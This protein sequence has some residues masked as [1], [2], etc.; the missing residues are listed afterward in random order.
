V[1]GKF[2]ISW[3]DTTRGGTEQVDADDFVEEGVWTT[4][5]R[6]KLGTTQQMEQVLRVRSENIQR[7]E[8]DE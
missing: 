3:N 4:F 2:K 1:T 6:L 5:R 7:I 8:R